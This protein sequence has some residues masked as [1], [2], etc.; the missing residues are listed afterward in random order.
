MS[1][2]H[3]PLLQGSKFRL[4]TAAGELAVSLYLLSEIPQAAEGA[5]QLSTND[6]GI[7]FSLAMRHSH[8]AML[9]L[10]T[11]SLH[12]LIVLTPAGFVTCK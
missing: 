7:H 1:V 9:H 12:P 6:K 10:L 11:V 5:C 8:I 4:G 3:S 2:L